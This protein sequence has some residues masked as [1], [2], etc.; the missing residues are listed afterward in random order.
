MNKLDIAIA[1][2]T[3]F[4]GLELIKKI[5]EHPF[6]NI[7][8]LFV[9]DSIDED[10]YKNLPK[11]ITNLP[12]LKK[13]D[14]NLINECDVFFS[15]LPHSQLH[16]IAK[17]I[18][19]E[20]VIDLSADF[21][22]P[23]IKTYEKWYNVKH[24]SSSIQK[25]AVYGLSEIYR[26]SIKNSNLISCP[27]CYP[28]SILI[29]LIP[30]LKNKIIELDNII[31]DSKSGYSG[32]GKK[33]NNNKDYPNLDENIAIYGVGYHRHIPEI[34]FY[35]SQFSDETLEISF[36]PHLIP[37]FRGMLS[38]IYVK[39]K[40]NINQIYEVINKFYKN[41]EFIKIFKSKM[42]NT[43]QVINTNNV[44]ISIN[45]SNIKDQ[46]VISS[47]IDNLLKGAAGQAIQNFNIRFGFDE[48]LG[49]V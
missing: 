8:Y 14:L 33:I 7:K 13:I 25:N 1:G 24:E 47:S 32:A 5:Y 21:R 34:N 31:A 26:E 39:S 43:D 3:G 28:T 49:L 46:F 42:I 36:S 40:K 30:L 20:V 10:I 9:K 27:G 2:A 11:K 22:F 17:D 12:K 29:P 23:N 18:S 38:T 16:K 41:D 4:V 19:S 15:S 35:S 45:S 37:T 44:N 48:Q 6:A